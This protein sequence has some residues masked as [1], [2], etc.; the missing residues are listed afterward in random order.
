MVTDNTFDNIDKKFQNDPMKTIGDMYI[1][2]MGD[3][4]LLH[5]LFGP[6][7]QH[8]SIRGSICRAQ[9]GPKSQT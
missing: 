6:I 4:L 9:S 8:N 3:L 5:C 1:F 2:F 7:R